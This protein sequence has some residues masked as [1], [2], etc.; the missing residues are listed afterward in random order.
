[1]EYCGPRG[2]PHQSV[3]LGWSQEDQD[4]ALAW[5]TWDARRCPLCGTNPADWKDDEG[6]ARIPPPWEWEMD[7]CYGCREKHRV[8]GAFDGDKS[9]IYSVPV[10]PDL[11][12]YDETLW[13][14]AS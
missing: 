5:M 6:R 7:V 12:E 4:A 2:I 10:I 13:T 1:M 9:G 8:E 14:D 11:S 3:F